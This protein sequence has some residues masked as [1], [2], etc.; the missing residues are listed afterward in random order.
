M[1]RPEADVPADRLIE[2]TRTVEAP[3]EL[4]WRV[5]TDPQHV[6]AWW[7]PTGFRTTTQQHDLRVGGQWRFTMHGPDGRDYENRI[8]FLEVQAPARLVYKHGGGKDVEPVNFTNTVTFEALPGE[9]QKTK[10]TMRAV[11]PNAAARE[12]VIRTY[13]AAEGGKQTMARM[14]EH[15]EA[16]A[17]AAPVPAGG[18]APFRLQ[19]V[20]RAPREL[21]WK[22]WTEREHLAQ[23]FGPKGC[24]LSIEQFELRPG[25]RVLYTMRWQGQGEMRGKWVMRTV[26]PPERLEFVTSFADA[27]GRTVRAPFADQ[28]PLEMLSVVTFEPHAGK[29]MG[30]VISLQTTAL[31]A[32]TGEQKVFDDGHASMTGGWGGT[33]DQLD[34]HLAKLG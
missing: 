15:V 13:N 26:Q 2:T 19:R 9:P 18:S 11:F 4:V 1:N 25:G 20:V 6:A 12:F 7:G 30:T 33:F 8:T 3:R 28:W 17:G 24:T 29:G 5:W 34:A 21:V 10:V 32:T 23:W 27:Q 14:A 31:G 22:V 16:L